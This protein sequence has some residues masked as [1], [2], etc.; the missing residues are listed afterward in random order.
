MRLRAR[1]E[2]CGRLILGPPA[3]AAQISVLGDNTVADGADAFDCD[4]DQVAW[5]EPD[6]WLPGEPNPARRARRDDVAWAER[7]E[8]R[9]ELDRAGYIDDHLGGLGG[10]HNLAVERRGQRRIRD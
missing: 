9:E 8:R 5:L 7:G 2:P 6:W 10:L 4:F 3:P 1:S